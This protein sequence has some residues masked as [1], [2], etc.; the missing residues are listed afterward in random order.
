ME[1]EEF[2]IET[3]EFSLCI[4]SY[5]SSRTT[6]GVLLQP[7]RP[8]GAENSKCQVLKFGK[9][10]GGKGPRRMHERGMLECGVI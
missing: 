7:Y 4:K 9:W 2:L 6:L 8:I 10:K 3:L 5:N 1:V